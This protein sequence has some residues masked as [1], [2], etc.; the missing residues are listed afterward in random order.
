MDLLDKYIAL[1]TQTTDRRDLWMYDKWGFTPAQ[2]ESAK[3]DP[4]AWNEMTQELQQR[5][6]DYGSTFKPVSGK[7]K[8]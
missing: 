2:I 6:R 7:Y 5:E 8:C 1:S 4:I 3:E